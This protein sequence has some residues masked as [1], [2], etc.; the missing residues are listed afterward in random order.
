VTAVGEAGRSAAADW[1]EIPGLS[2]RLMCGALSDYG[3]D[4]LPLL[5]ASRIPLDVL[6]VPDR[7]IGW[8]QEL[9]FQRAFAD[10][11]AGCPDIWV[12]TGRRYL[13]PIFDDFGMAMMAAP[14]LRHWRGLT[15]SVKTYFSVGEYR[16]VD[17]SSASA[18]IEL[19][20]PS[21]VDR[22]GAFFAFTVCRDV[23]ATSRC[24]DDLWQK[25]FA[26]GRVELPLTSIPQPLRDAVSTPII[27]NS[28]TIRWLWPEALLDI[29][30]PRSNKM[31]FDLH[32]DRAQRAA[33]WLRASFAMDEQV[34]AILG[35]P[36]NAGLSLSRVA[37]ELT[38]SRRT[39]QRHLDTCGVSFRKLRD[40]ARLREAC[41]LL[42]ET[43]M[44]V[45]EVA[46]CLGFLEVASFSNAFRR[47]TGRTPTQYRLR[48]ADR[49][50]CE[51]PDAFRA[52]SRLRN[53]HG[54]TPIS[55]SAR[56]S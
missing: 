33:S 4:P 44:P 53:S 19:T 38:M 32:A 20:M 42:G 28:D 23:A 54:T 1:S 29:P 18:G 37:A 41:R 13:Y 31:L 36:E 12:E 25:P 7:R 30:L 9:A 6:D 21:D 15:T 26:E 34:A 51:S 8:A 55:A 40:D 48:H 5:R 2:V 14:T 16:S 45:S 35:R 56:P 22:E 10:R 3:V 39:L 47:W 46:N 43:S 52:V 24:L 27:A 49:V 11:T 50:T 17:R